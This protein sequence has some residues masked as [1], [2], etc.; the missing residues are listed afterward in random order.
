VIN[1][2]PGAPS[3]PDPSNNSPIVAI[4]ADLSWTCSDSDGDTLKYD[5]YFGTSSSPP[6]KVSNQTDAVY[7]PGMMNYNTQYYWK[8]IS[9]DAHNVSNVSA[10]WTFNTTSPAENPPAVTS[11]NPANG[12]SA[13]SVSLSVLSVTIEDA[14]GDPFNWTI[15]TSP[16]IGT[17]NGSAA[18]NGTK[19]CNLTVSL[20][21]SSTYTWY[22]KVTDGVHWTNKTYWFTTESQGGGYSPGEPPATPPNAKPIAK[23]SPDVPYQGLVNTDIIFDGSGSVDSDG[24]ITAWFWD[25]GDGTT[26][27]GMTIAHAF[28]FVG[29]YT[30]NLT[31]TDDDKAKD[32]DTT[33]CH[34]KYKNR[35][36]VRPIV[37]GPVSGMK[38]TAYTYTAFSTDMDNDTIQYTFDWGDNESQ[39]SGYVSSAMNYTVNHSWASAGRYIV[40]VTVSD[41]LLENSSTITVYINAMQARGVGYL[42]DYD[43]DGVFDAFYSEAS[44]QTVT[45]IQKRDDSYLID[46]DGDGDWDYVY[47]A[48]HGITSYQKPSKTPGFDFVCVIC[49]IACILFLRRYRKK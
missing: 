32:F 35:S 36:P 12:T 20:T 26:G 15:T 5:V 10:V 48:T 18:S 16:N 49:V 31:V 21:Y 13:V 38:N 34:V 45:T 19:T 40:T 17:N 22:V 47:N 3:N 41:A 4:N 37:T 44:K 14:D 28:S 25:F 30:V 24:N 43:G 9:W 6:K 11:L 7:D 33:T 23:A 46:G 29:T 8:I 42:L 1:H 2:P 27:T 39:S